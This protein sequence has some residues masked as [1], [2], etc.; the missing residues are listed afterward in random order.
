MKITITCSNSGC[1]EDIAINSDNFD[2][3]SES[4]GTHTT[5]YGISGEVECPHCGKINSVNLVLDV[6]DD[7]GEVL[8]S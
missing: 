6:V 5:Q 3:E 1:R 2:V 8:Q 4:S 7:T